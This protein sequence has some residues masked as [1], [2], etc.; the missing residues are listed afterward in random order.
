MKRKYFSVLFLFLIL[1]AVFI[2]RDDS[3]R[4]MKTF[5]QSKADDIA[6][7]LVIDPGHGGRDPGKV[8]VNNALEKEIN[9]KVSLKLRDLLE[10]KGIHV[11]MTREEDMGLYEETDSNRKRADLN[12]RIEIINSSDAEFAISIHQNS[13]TEEYVK[14][15]QVFYHQQSGEGKKLALI[16]QEELKKGLQDGNHRNAKSNESYFM[17]KKTDCP[18]VIIECGYLSNNA[19]ASLLVKEAYQDKLA[20]VICQGVLAYIDKK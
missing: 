19:E 11:I 9:L 17:L 7:T 18:L 3:L 8:G 6:L 10:E 16:L 1:A 20:Q 2:S 14:G 15:A 12:K 13:F 4:V 5:F